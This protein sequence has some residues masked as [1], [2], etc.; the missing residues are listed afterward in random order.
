[1]PFTCCSYWYMPFAGVLDSISLSLGVALYQNTACG[2]SLDSVVTPLRNAVTF[3]DIS[4]PVSHLYAPFV[5]ESEESLTTKSWGIIHQY[6]SWPT[7][8]KDGRLFLHDGW[9]NLNCQ[10]APHSETCRPAIGQRQES[11]ATVMGYVHT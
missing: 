11:I 9:H 5:C 7:M 1:M 4:A 10:L 2:Y 6:F 8:F 3:W